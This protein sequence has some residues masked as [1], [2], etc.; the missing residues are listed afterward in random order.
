MIDFDTYNFAP[1]MNYPDNLQKVDLSRGFDEEKLASL[2]WGAGGYNEKREGMYLAPHFEGK[3]Y[4]HMGIDIWASA[5]RPVFSIYD[6]KVAYMR[7]NDRKGDYGGT[8]ITVHKLAD[9]TLYA[10]HGHLSKASLEMVKPGQDVSKGDKIA[11]LGNREENG[12]W[13]PHLHFQLS[14]EDPGEADMPGVVSDAS[15]AEA[16]RTYPDPK[17]VLGNLF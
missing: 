2:E 11:E 9:T 6:G 17:L 15:H 10:L 3:R 5:G 4:I 14:W 8:I 1:V 13:I 16:L 7:N 12:G